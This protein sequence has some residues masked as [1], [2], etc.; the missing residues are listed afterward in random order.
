MLVGRS[1]DPGSSTFAEGLVAVVG[2]LVELVRRS[3]RFCQ[4]AVVVARNCSLIGSF[5]ISKVL[6]LPQLLLCPQF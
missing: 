4:Q 1:L 5:V 2:M 3:I 6:E